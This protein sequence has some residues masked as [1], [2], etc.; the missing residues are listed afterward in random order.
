M[1]DQAHC[2][3]TVT[4]MRADEVSVE[5]VT[6]LLRGVVDPE[7]MCNIV[8]LGMAKG[9]SIAQEACVVTVA[10]TIAGCPRKADIQKA[11]RARLGHL[12]LNGVSIEWGEMDAQERSHAMTV[13]RQRAKETAETTRVNSATR[14]LA[15]ASGKG[16]VGK[17]TLSAALAVLLARRGERVG[18]LDADVGGFS[19]PSMMGVTG[20]LGAEVQ[21]GKAVIIPALCDVGGAA[22]IQ[23]ASVGLLTDNDDKALMWRGRL[24]QRAVEQLLCDVAWDRDLTYLLIDLPPGT[25][26]IPMAVARMLSNLD[27]LIVTTPSEAVARV[28][29]R[30]GDMA[31]RYNVSVAGVV[32]NMSYQ[33]QPDGTRE[34]TLGMGGGSA[35][36]S[37]LGVPLLGQI[38]LDRELAAAFENGVPGALDRD[39]ETLSAL[40]AVTDRVV[41]L[42]PPLRRA[43]CAE[44]IFERVSK[45]LDER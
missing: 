5:L 11:V 31:R 16:G 27:L 10:L 19:I 9:V 43:G 22:P 39:S 13:A 29:Q 37:S 23:V 26:D 34:A 33:T 12:F 17:S 42:L 44:D 14:V 38:P 40:N 21:D 36:S 2:T 7:L 45:A 3:R 15:V 24:L 20:R 4:C 35:V 18:I 25:A 1:D 41:A 8:E 6:E 28:S 32:E 30:V